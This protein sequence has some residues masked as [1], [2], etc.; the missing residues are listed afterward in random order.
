MVG[1]G[2]YVEDVR[3]EI[4]GMTQKLAIFSTLIL[5]VIGLLS[6]FIIYAGAR[7]DKQRKQA[8]ESLRSSEEKFRNIVENANDIIYMLNNRGYLIYVSRSWTE[9]LGHS[10]EEVLNKK[11]T[12]FVHEKDMPSLSKAIQHL[13]HTGK[14]IQGVNYRLK[15][16]DGHWVWHTSNASRYQICNGKH[17]FIGISRDIS[18]RMHFIEALMES[19]EKYRILAENATDIIWTMDLNQKFTYCSSAIYKVLGYTPEELLQTEVYGIIP[20]LYTDM[21]KKVVQAKIGQAQKGHPEAQET[22]SVEVQ[23]LTKSGKFVWCEITGRVV[24]DKVTN[25]PRYII[26]ATRDISDRKSSQLSLDNERR[27]LRNIMDATQDLIFIKDTEGRYLEGN[28]SFLD[29]RGIEREDL[30]GKTD[31][32]FFNEKRAKIMRIEDTQ[33]L[34]KPGGSLQKLWFTDTKGKKHLYDTLKSALID[35]E[36]NIKGVVGISRDVTEKHEIEKQKSKIEEKLRHTYKLE[37]IG[38]LAGGI[39]HD[40]NNILSIIVGN[41]ELALDDLKDEKHPR[42]ELQQ[43][44]NAS[45]RAKELVGQISTFSRLGQ[46]QKQVLNINDVV[47]DALKMLRAA[48]PSTIEIRK[49]FEPKGLLVFADQTQIHQVIINLCTNSAHAMHNKGGILDIIVEQVFINKQKAEDIAGIEIGKHVKIVVKDTGKG[50]TPTVLA[51]MFDPYFTTKK[52]GEGTGLGMSVVHG[53]AREHDGAITVKSVVDK[54][55]SV[56]MFLPLSELNGIEKQ[57]RSEDTNLAGKETILYVDDEPELVRLGENIL[58][59]L[60]YKVIGETSSTKALEIFKADPNKFDAV[61]TDQTMPRITGV[62]LAADILK[63]RPEIPIIICTGYIEE[64][65]Q[66]EANQIGVAM[67]VSKPVSKQEIAKV[68]RSTLEKAATERS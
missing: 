25:K 28:K 54:G 63:I 60:G 40:F 7:S 49:S 11:Y 51:R 66:E 5:F 53:I 16:K 31:Y 12:D 9:H 23:L 17:A 46:T 47:E 56:Y 50:M 6:A 1:T 42:K 8:I 39:A 58:N 57:Q 35:S 10:P 67:F 36:G 3:A 2:I 37:S 14:K 29:F 27:L 55:T 13:M 19:E 32:S 33:V 22:V 52:A 64:S 4:Q 62:E 15:H 59:R 44:L 24:T 34:H 38:T 21:I 65:I 41:T 48:L 45:Y 26:G 30:L 61:I 18:E 20:P 43:V 68:L